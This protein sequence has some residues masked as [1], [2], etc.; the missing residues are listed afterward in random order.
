MAT[1]DVVSPA[2]HPLQLS[3][4]SP[5]S[6]SELRNMKFTKFP[7]FGSA[8]L[9][10]GA[11]AALVGCM[12]QNSAPSEG[13]PIAIVHEEL[14]THSTYFTA[15][16]LKDEAGNT[17][18]SFD[19]QGYKCKV[20]DEFGGVYNQ[21]QGNTY[22]DGSKW[23]FQNLSV[24][25][26]GQ[27]YTTR[28]CADA[29]H[30]GDW[31]YCVNNGKMTIRARPDTIN[32]TNNSDCATFWGGSM[33]TKNY[34][35]GRIISKHK[36]D[37]QYGYLESR[38][39]LPFQG[40][41]K[42]SGVWP[43]WWMLP[44][45]IVEG[46]PPGSTPW[47]WA[48]EIDIMEW[49]SPNGK[50]ASNSIY[51]GNDGNMDA[52]NDWPE[53]G[54]GDDCYNEGGNHYWSST[55]NRYGSKWK[56][57]DWS[58]TGAA[59]T[60]GSAGAGYH[61]WHTYA[62][63]WTPTKIRIWV[64]GVTQGYVRTDGSANEYNVPMFMIYNVA[65]GGDLGGTI[66]PTMDW[67]KVTLET[68]YVR[69]YQLGGSDTCADPAGG[70][71]GTCSDGIRNQ[72]ETGVDCGGS[73]CAACAT[74]ND[75]AQNQGESAIDC[76]GPCA[77]CATQAMLYADCNYGGTA[78]A[79]A[80]GDYDMANLGLANDTMSSIKVSPGYQAVLYQ[81]I[82]FGGFATI[83]TGDTICLTG[84]GTNRTSGS[85]DNDV[86]SIR[87]QPVNTQEPPQIHLGSTVRAE[88]GIQG[89][90]QK[91]YAPGNG[92]TGTTVGYF[93]GNTTDYIKFI[94]VNLTGVGGLGLRVAGDAS[95]AGK[96][97]EVRADSVTGGTLLGTFTMSS[98]GGWTTWQDK[99]L[100]FS[101]PISGSHDLYLRA[102]TNATGILNIE[103]IT[104]KG[105]SATCSDGVQN[106]GE[107]GVD[108]GG[109]CA[110]CGGGGAGF[111]ITAST[112]NA[113]GRI[114]GG[115]AVGL[116]NCTEGGQNVMDAGC[117]EYV[118]YDYVNF[119]N[120]GSFEV[121]AASAN[122]ARPTNLEFRR[123]SATGP[124]M[125]T[126]N[127]TTYGGWQNWQNYTCNL[128]S[129]QSG[130]GNLFVVWKGTCDAGGNGYNQLHNVR[131]IKGVA[132]AVTC[133]DSCSAHSASCGT[134]SNNCGGTLSCGSCG[135]GYSC[136][137]NKCVLTATGSHEGT[138]MGADASATTFNANSC[139]P[140]GGGAIMGASACTI[141]WGGVDMGGNTQATVTY[142]NGE[143][144]GD[145]MKVT[146]NG[147]QIGSNIS[148]NNTGGWTTSSSSTVT[149]G[150]QSG[151]G[152]LCV[153]PVAGS[154]WIAKI[155]QISF[156]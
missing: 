25:G 45:T 10:F 137:A 5:G 62:M 66:D 144:A 96:Q 53:Y 60:E 78:V 27:A 69:W 43:A 77:P 142:A 87:I 120:L 89:G 16:N 154:G 64:D 41:T 49:Q 54:G 153:A 139:H 12:S 84:N 145:T 133:Q 23:S 65:V 152:T 143:A 115:G 38:I 8:V 100:T 67:S 107:T 70:T 68:D 81:D 132:G 3:A 110:A 92:S 37:L 79:K 82:G 131:T 113:S 126:C 95:T 121:R 21:G 32:C 75:G 57:N 108:C 6:E 13:E 147:T 117:D 97:M 146:F 48:P 22:I 71:G 86:T 114:G 105:A 73:G 74:C 35:S 130:T 59:G 2:A 127:L 111:S 93:D 119:S 11:S 102:L 123:D 7:L 63:E 34:T 85:W 52:C 33:G 98:T 122:S 116:E 1:A 40:V 134:V 129:S 20:N 47:P 39:R 109:P 103:T 46:P 118:R 124:L 58:G 156:K 29:A 141:C 135:T 83:L 106:Q 128:T 4:Q 31:N 150:A 88:T 104:L 61:G 101:N 44:K 91:E 80:A 17:L 76:G 72:A 56:V 148:A 24:N 19:A 151:V 9:A 140:E 15:T 99:S 30:S 18:P 51:I 149:F 138:R 136:T 112:F 90:T 55:Y 36:V 94:N 42:K 14:T 50:M 28:Q 125:A 155:N 26:E